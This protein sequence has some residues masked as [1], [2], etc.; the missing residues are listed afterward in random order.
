MTILPNGHV[1]IGTT[2]PDVPLHITAIKSGVPV[3][4]MM[5]QD[6]LGLVQRLIQIVIGLNHMCH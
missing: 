1:G 5:G 3:W 4:Q 6:I 2:S